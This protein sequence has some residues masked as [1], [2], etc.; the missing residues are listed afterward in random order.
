LALSVYLDASVLVPLFIDDNFSERAEALLS[1]GAEP[2]VGDFAGAEFASVVSR[3]VRERRL[4]VAEGQNAF[5]TF[6]A[7]MSRVQGPVETTA[8]D[9]SAAT[10]ILRRLD[11]PVRTADALHL[12]IAGRLASELATFDAK[13]AESARRLGL[14]LA[15]V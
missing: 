5:V 1:A 2:V 6:D 12:A 7:W 14:A 9:V 8:A 10:A 11:L 13:M 3:K 4:T 15:T